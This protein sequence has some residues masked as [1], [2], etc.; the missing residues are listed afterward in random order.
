VRSQCLDW[1]AAVDSG[2][3]MVQ[4]YAQNKRRKQEIYLRRQAATRLPNPTLF[5]TRVPKAIHVLGVNIAHK[6]RAL[7]WSTGCPNAPSCKRW[8]PKVAQYLKFFDPCLCPSKSILVCDVVN[9]NGRL[10]TSV[11]HRCK[12][13][14]SLLK[15]RMPPP[16]AKLTWRNYLW[17]NMIGWSK[18]GA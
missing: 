4:Q 6:K 17:S 15:M 7:C 1:L 14:V 12:A 11:V 10:R 3:R 18:N 2:G 5:T 9:N 8:I 13:V 16:P